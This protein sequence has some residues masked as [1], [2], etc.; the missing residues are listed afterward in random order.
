MSS[1]SPVVPTT[2]LVD[3][4]AVLRWLEAEV[5]GH[6]LKHIL[7]VEQ[8]SMALAQAYDLDVAKAA[9]AGLMHD[10]AKYYRPQRLLAL[11]REAGL[12]IDPVDEADPRLLHAAVSA[13]VA[14]QEFGV[15][16]A[17]ILAAIA[18]HTLGEPGM[19]PLSCV[20]FLA[21]SLEPGRGDTPELKELRK[22]AHHNLQRAVWMTC[23][24]TLA[25]LIAQKLLIHPRMILT[26]NWAMQQ[27]QT[28]A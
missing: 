27:A 25:H 8:M 1:S 12:A 9:Q 15:Q 13:V 7:R 3:R 28:K 19:S 20:V 17:E 16:D 4:E 23:D 2:S 18:H 5:P 24:R 11:A 14:Q 21:D 22:V 10:L 26:R 6:R